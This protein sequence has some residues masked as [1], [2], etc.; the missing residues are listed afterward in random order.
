MHA[1]RTL[2]FLGACEELE[3]RLAA[4][5]EALREVRGTGGE[6][7]AAARA[8]LKKAKGEMRA[9]R[10]WARTLGQPAE[11]TPGRDATIRVGGAVG[12]GMGR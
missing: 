3:E 6:Q 8:E 9:F 11:G 10:E 5:K 12:H 7:E 4:A 1:R 2:E